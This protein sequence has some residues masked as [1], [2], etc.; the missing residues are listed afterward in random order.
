MNNQYELIIRVGGGGGGNENSSAPA[1]G[2][3][4]STGQNGGG[5]TSF[6]D[7]VKNFAK[8]WSGAT[9]AKQAMSYGISRVGVETGNMQAQATLG[10][11]ESVATKAIDTGIAFALNPVLGVTKLASEGLSLIQRLDTFN[12]D[13]R[14][15]GIALEQARLRAGSAVN[16][17]RAFE[18][19]A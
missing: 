8:V 10:L 11:I 15:E 12:Y 16:R 14:M 18:T 17:S 13:R 6:R 7:F 19:N 5:G 2:G 3:G 1:A 4:D 9:L